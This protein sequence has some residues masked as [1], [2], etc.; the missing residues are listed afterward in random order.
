[1]LIDQTISFDLKMLGLNLVRAEKYMSAV[2]GTA[3]MYGRF[4]WSYFLT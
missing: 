2:H 3:D 4:I 1:M